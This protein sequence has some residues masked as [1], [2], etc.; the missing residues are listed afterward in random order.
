MHTV[1]LYVNGNVYYELEPD[2]WTEIKAYFDDS[3]VFTVPAVH[4]EEL[5]EKLVIQ[6]AKERIQQLLP[7]K[8][9][10]DSRFSTEFSIHFL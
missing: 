1:D 9:L 4:D 7:Y 3:V 6:S 10:E 5:I 2:N 8:I